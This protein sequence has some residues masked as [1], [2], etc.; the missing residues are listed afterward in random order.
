VITSAH[1]LVIYGCGGHA[2][3]VAD[4][5]LFNGIEHIIFVDENAQPHEKIFGFDVVP[6]IDAQDNIGYFIAVGDNRRRATLFDARGNKTLPSL[7]ARDAYIGI[8]AEIAEACFVSHAAHIGPNVRIGENSI[9]NTRSVIEHDCIIGKHC[10]ISVN[11]VVAGASQIGDFVM[12]GAGA[13]I[14]DKINITSHVMIAAGAVVVNDIDE[15][16]IYMGVPARKM[17]NMP[18]F[19]TANEDGSGDDNVT[20]IKL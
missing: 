5:A 4:V 12:V 14:I 19:T 16:G 2:R 18:A 7:I 8:N 9:I 6:D 13:V 20:G 10:H 15:P 11:A 3:S 1:S 17:Y